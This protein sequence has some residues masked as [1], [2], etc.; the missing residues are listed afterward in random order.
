[1]S[2][3]KEINPSPNTLLFYKT[4]VGRE[5]KEARDDWARSLAVTL[6]E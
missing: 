2:T 1:M 5:G 6:M 3:G 4:G